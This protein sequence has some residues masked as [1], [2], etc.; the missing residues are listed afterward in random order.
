MKKVVIFVVVVIIVFVG[1]FL[2]GD[3]V[4]DWKKNDNSFE[5]ISCEQIKINFPDLN[6]KI[7]ILCDLEAK[8]YQ[9]YTDETEERLAYLN[10]AFEWESLGGLELKDEFYQRA[11]DIYRAFED[12]YHDESYT[13]KWNM[14][15]LY[16]DL[17]DYTKAEEY[18]KKAI[19]A[20]NADAEPYVALLNLYLQD[21]L[22]ANYRSVKELLDFAQENVSINREFFLDR[23]LKYLE[24]IGETAKADEVR[25]ELKLSFPDKY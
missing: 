2:F 11:V 14:A 6:E 19:V 20:N 22:P 15:H 7:A 9:Q 16:I 17:K 23:Y 13:V 25:Q 8:I 24:K 3:K 12:K 1:W 4:G 10:V 5:N 21:N 18:F